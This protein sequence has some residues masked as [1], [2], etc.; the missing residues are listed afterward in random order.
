MVAFSLS[1]FLSFSCPIS[2]LF[3]DVLS[4]RG[5]GL[6]KKTTKPSPDPLNGKLKMDQHAEEK[7]K[8]TTKT[9]TDIEDFC[10]KLF[11]SADVE[12]CSVCDLENV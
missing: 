4:H 6:V 12:E 11:H 2:F 3:G 7:K 5:S 10:Q 9:G 1:L 8:Q